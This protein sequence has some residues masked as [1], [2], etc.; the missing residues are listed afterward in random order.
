VNSGLIWEA[1]QTHAR[2][3][4]AAGPPDHR[5][6]PNRRL[7][8][9]ENDVEADEC[10]WVGKPL[11]CQFPNI[12]RRQLNA[13]PPGSI[14]LANNNQPPNADAGADTC[15]PGT[16]AAFVSQ[17]YM[18]LKMTFAG[19]NPGQCC[20]SIKVSNQRRPCD[21]FDRGNAIL[22]GGVAG[23]VSEDNALGRQRRR[24]G[25]LQDGAVD[26][27]PHQDVGNRHA[28][29]LRRGLAGDA[30]L[31]GKVLFVA[32][33]RGCAR[34]DTLR[35]RSTS[36][37]TVTKPCDFAE[38]EQA[39]AHYKS[40]ASVLWTEGLNRLANGADELLCPDARPPPGL[41]RWIPAEWNKQHRGW[42]AWVPKTPKPNIPG[43]V[44]GCQRDEYPFF[45]LAHG[46]GFV[47][48]DQLVRV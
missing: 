30:L 31:G 38:W 14:H 28:C 34:T 8:C 5:V 45:R 4:G 12:L 48:Y 44:K 46:P 16:M 35:E 36:S 39:C 47:L 20:K 24:L 1:Q 13:S 3:S 21:E 29:L 15:F 42:L 43:R 41:G 17:E 33:N 22:A 27:I 32:I 11:F 40:A 6:N 25:E 10:A 9:I 7:L 19:M 37:T 18:K 2:W 23:G 26:T